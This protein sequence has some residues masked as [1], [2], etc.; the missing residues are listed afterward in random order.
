MIKVNSHKAKRGRKVVTIKSHSRSGNMGANLKSSFLDRV[1]VNPEG[2]YSI[3]IK[4]K[5]YP[6]KSLPDSKV[7]GLIR[8][9]KNSCGKY[10]NKHIRG[11]KDYF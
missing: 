2:G 4:G 11:K 6:Y 9:I 3:I 8:G 1:E 10:Y 5:S 7:G